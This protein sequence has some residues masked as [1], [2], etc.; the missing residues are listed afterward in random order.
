M[1][2]YFLFILAALSFTNAANAAQRLPDFSS[3]LMAIGHGQELS[4]VVDF[5]E[6]DAAKKALFSGALAGVYK[7][8][9]FI[10][11]ADGSLAA[12]LTHFTRANPMFPEQSV[13]E[14]AR[15]TI[16]KDNTL[17]LKMIVLDAETYK[18]ISDSYEM[19][20][21]FDDVRFYAHKH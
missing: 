7:P 3:I 19:N 16:K 17:N 10:Q 2:K 12:S 13:F 1:K 21:K 8:D 9:A 18:P 5:T 20:C 6:C 11:S 4:I 15:Y 14:H